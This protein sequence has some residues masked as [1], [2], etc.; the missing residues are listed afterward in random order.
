MIHPNDITLVK[1]YALNRVRFMRQFYNFAKDRSIKNSPHD[2]S[3]F[4]SILGSMG[5]KQFKPNMFRAILNLQE[6]NMAIDAGIRAD[7][8]V[9]IAPIPVDENLP[10]DIPVKTQIPA[11]NATNSTFER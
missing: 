7:P 9:I 10:V 1:P 8:Q 4:K 6:N 3:D 11:A 2:L 5:S